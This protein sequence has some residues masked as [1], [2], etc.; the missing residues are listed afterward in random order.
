MS[1]IERA[2]QRL[3][4]LERAGAQWSGDPTG[5]PSPQRDSGPSLIER[6]A[7]KLGTVDAARVSSEHTSSATRAEEALRNAGDEDLD[8]AVFAPR[9]P[10]LRDALRP[11]PTPIGG[12]PRLRDA[13][14]RAGRLELDFSKLASLGYL[15]PGDSESAIA[16]EFRKIKRPLIQAC[17][18]KLATPVVNANRIM[19]TSSVEGEGK[20]FSTLNLALSMSMERDST[21]LLVDADTTRR[22]LSRLV[23]SDA[24]RGLLD[25]LASEEPDVSEVLLRTNIE[26]L[27]FLPAGARRR[28]ATELLASAAMANLVEHLASRYKDRILVFDT[29][30]LLAAPEAASLASHMGQILVVVE[31][32]RTTHKVLTSGLAT[33]RSCPVVVTILNKA[34][35]AGQEYY[36]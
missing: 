13:P 8:L 32:N 12:P 31:A 2:A 29:P 21:V 35:N 16:N 25:L 1:L 3:K 15:E 22:T 7:R 24:N 26:R 34:S 9:E 11:G 27:T 20:T 19:V 23:G 5:G 36:Y 30:P 28:H 10:K 14:G 18:G 4:E 17:K 6:A 33:I